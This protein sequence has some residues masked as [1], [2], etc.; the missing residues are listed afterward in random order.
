MLEELDYPSSILE[1]SLT[2]T[3]RSSIDS[4]ENTS[5][6]PSSIM[7]AH[8]HPSLRCSDCSKRIDP[9]PSTD[10]ALQQDIAPLS[11]EPVETLLLTVSELRSRLR[12]L[13]VD[14][15]TCMSSSNVVNYKRES[16]HDVADGAAESAPMVPQEMLVGTR[17]TPG[18]EASKCP[19]PSLSISTFPNISLL[20]S[21]LTCLGMLPLSF[22]IAARCEGE[23]CVD[24]AVW[25]RVIVYSSAAGVCMGLCMGLWIVQAAH[26]QWRLCARSGLR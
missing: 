5:E 1:P 25:A 19:L 11:S 6:S 23:A 7:V 26:E 13:G 4:D 12:G 14:T 2:P 20:H 24:L 17:S 22:I 10:A 21:F 16:Q 9:T 15:T 3:K 8:G 18:E